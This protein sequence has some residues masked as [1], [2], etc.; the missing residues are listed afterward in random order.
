M[1]GIK[2]DVVIP[3]Y[4]PTRSL[5]ELVRKLLSQS[6]PVGHI[7]IINTGEAYFDEA[8]LPPMP[9]VD[10][11]HIPEEEFDH[12][13]TR[14]M[15]AG[16]SDA[17]YLLFMTQDAMPADRFLVE[18][19]LGAFSD[20]LVKAAYARQLPKPDCLLVE[21]C[22]RH[23]NYPRASCV[24]TLKDLP[25]LG[26]KAYFCSNVCAMYEK[27][28]FDRMKGFSAPAI[29][30]EDMV[31]AARIEHLGYG[32]AYVAEAEVFHSHNYSNIQQFKRNFDNGVSQAMHPEIFGQVPSLGEGRKMVHFVTGYLWK[33]GRGYLIP[34]FLGQCA[35]RLAGFRLGKAY[36]H[37]PR[38]VVRRCSLS[39]DFFRKR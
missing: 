28:T 37:L 11:F 17:D 26:V 23:Y 38:S 34:G 36:R 18:R 20:P 19:L 6:C 4:K 35:Y 33:N 39:P 14:N 7:L 15:G 25:A 2:I 27:Y 1:Q 24:R 21:G 3:T 9:K 10:I 13:G 32:V 29:F 8:L 12:A 16:L 5:N 30:N 22:V 31:Y